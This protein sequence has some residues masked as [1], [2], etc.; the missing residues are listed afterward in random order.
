MKTAHSNIKNA[1]VNPVLEI[2]LFRNITNDKKLVPE[3]LLAEVIINKVSSLLANLWALVSRGS[4]RSKR[5]QSTFWYVG[6]RGSDEQISRQ[7]EGDMH[8][9]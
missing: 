8:S 9:R 6:K 4:S 7:K 1:I 2:D 5:N 3:T